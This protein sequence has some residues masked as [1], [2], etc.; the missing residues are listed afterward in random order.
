MDKAFIVYLSTGSWESFHEEPIRGFG[1]QE[2]A[3]VF[4]EQQHKDIHK[5]VEQSKKCTECTHRNWD[6]LSE[7]KNIQD[8]IDF[9]KLSCDKVDII[10]DEVFSLYCKNRLS[11]DIEEYNHFAI[12]EIPFGL[13]G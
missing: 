6:M 7:N 2:E 10:H 1:T 13:E 8:I 12:W 9:C 3:E 11:F 4:A 5:W